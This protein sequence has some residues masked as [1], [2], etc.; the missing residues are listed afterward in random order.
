[1]M[2]LEQ[3]LFEGAGAGGMRTEMALLFGE[4]WPHLLHKFV[5]ETCDQDDAAR[6]LGCGHS[7]SNQF[8]NFSHSPAAIPGMCFAGDFE[9]WKKPRVPHRKA[10]GKTR[11]PMWK[12]RSAP[13]PPA[14]TTRVARRS[15]LRADATIT[16]SASASAAAA[17]ETTAAVR[18]AATV[19]RQRLERDNQ[20]ELRRGTGLGKLELGDDLSAEAPTAMDVVSSVALLVQTMAWRKFSVT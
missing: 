15:S 2:P 18:R 16:A 6:W 5:D 10:A 20:V 11:E 8:H 1:M 19:A 14:V 13:M 12:D 17:A 3:R 9:A 7:S 4:F